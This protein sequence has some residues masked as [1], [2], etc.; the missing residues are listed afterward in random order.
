[1]PPTARNSSI[2]MPGS[3]DDSTHGVTSTSPNWEPI[4]RLRNCRRP[5]HLSRVAGLTAYVLLWLNV[6]IGLGLRTSVGPPF[7]KRWRVAD[8]H[9][10]IA[11]LS[12]GFLA[13]HIIILVG[14]R[15]HAFSFVELWV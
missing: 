4:D 2:V 13:R 7:V 12:L 6:S 10:F 11:V 9:Q 1:M 3:V 15:Q 14:L 5:A 8:L